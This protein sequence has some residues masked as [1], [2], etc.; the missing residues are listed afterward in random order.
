MVERAYAEP[1]IGR[2][3]RHDMPKS[4]L[5]SMTAGAPIPN[6]AGVPA[7]VGELEVLCLRATSS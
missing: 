1:A 3:D 4:A 2:P 5:V 7:D 6:E